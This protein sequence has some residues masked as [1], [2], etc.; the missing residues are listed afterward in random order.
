MTLDQLNKLVRR[1]DLSANDLKELRR[2][3]R[4]EGR[5]DGVELIEEVLDARFPN[6]DKP[7]LVGLGSGEKKEVTRVQLFGDNREFSDAATAFGWMVDR[8][9]QE[10]K[11]GIDI[12]PALL[13]IIN[14]GSVRKSLARSPDELYPKNSN[15]PAKPTD[16]YELTNGWFLATH[17]NNKKKLD[18]LATVMGIFGV[19]HGEWECQMPHAEYPDLD[20]LLAEVLKKNNGTES[21]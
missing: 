11:I 18:V 16:W 13:G 10:K 14:T 9:F 5:L 3:E 4:N 8:V 2:T 17:M 7:S 15:F 12:D 6:W 20:E 1:T 19:K 21:P